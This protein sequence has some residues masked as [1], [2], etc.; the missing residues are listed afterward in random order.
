MSL[1]YVYPDLFVKSDDLKEKKHG[2]LC[3]IILN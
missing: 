3:L 1:I 2:L